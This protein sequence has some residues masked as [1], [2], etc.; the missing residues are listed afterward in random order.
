MLWGMV[1]QR[2][3]TLQEAADYLGYS[4]SGI[5]KLI[6]RKAINYSKPA[7]RYRFK[8]EWLDAFV[9]SGQLIETAKPSRSS[10]KPAQPLASSHGL[11]WSLCP[12]VFLKEKLTG[13][14]LD[15]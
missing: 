2:L 5:R 14:N 4:E 9:Q 7:G 8:P 11:D 1:G 15:F 13:K 12:P 10:V 6:R 3:L